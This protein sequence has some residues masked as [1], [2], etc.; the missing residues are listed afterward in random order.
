[1]AVMLLVAAGFA[2]ELP[3]KK[4]LNLAA[5][6]TMVAASEAEAAKRGVSVTLTIL[7]D[8]GTTI[9]LEKGDGQNTNTIEWARGKAR[10][11]ALYGMPSKDGADWAKGNAAPVVFPAYFAAQG[12]L[13]IKVNGQVIGGIA[14]SGADSPVDEAIAQAGLDALAKAWQ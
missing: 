4:Y 2:A 11:A 9:F 7:D 13:P 10:F 1:M 14:A 3:S 6:K 8:E 5:I 12:G